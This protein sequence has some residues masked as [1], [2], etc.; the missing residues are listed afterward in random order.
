MPENTEELIRRLCRYN[1]IREVIK[2][3]ENKF[4][5]ATVRELLN[6]FL[7]EKEIKISD[8]EKKSGQSEY[9]YKIFNGVRKASRDVLISIAYGME[10]SLGETQELLTTA[11]FAPLNPRDKRDLI[12]IYGLLNR[13]SIFEIRAILE[14]VGE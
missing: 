14:E 6:R 2:N 3:N 8:V 1:D 7:L 5:K 11:Y 9:V 4:K 10:L 13:K 12:Y